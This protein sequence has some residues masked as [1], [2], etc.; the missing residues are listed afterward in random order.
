VRNLL[1][2]EPKELVKDGWW[3]SQSLREGWIS[4]DYILNYPN[5][6]PKEMMSMETSLLN[7]AGKKVWFSWVNSM[8]PN[9]NYVGVGLDITKYKNG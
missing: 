9:G 1:G 2:Y 8:L 6:L 5:I 7:K 3:R 4:R